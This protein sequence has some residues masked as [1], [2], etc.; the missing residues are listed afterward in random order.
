MSEDITCS[1]FISRNVKERKKIMS[2]K[3]ITYSIVKSLGVISKSNKHTK[4]LNLISWNGREPVYDLRVW[5]TET[6][7][8]KAPCKGISLSEEDL[9]TLKELLSRINVGV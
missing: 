1:F 5:K 3:E 4:E 2:T 7:G 9:L 6:D 8:S